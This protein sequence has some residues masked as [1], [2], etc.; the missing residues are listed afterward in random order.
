MKIKEQ[1]FEPASFLKKEVLRI[2]FSDVTKRE[3]PELYTAL[4]K[5][6]RNRRG[7]T[8]SIS[9]NG[10]DFWFKNEAELDTFIN[11]FSIAMRVMDPDVLAGYGEAKWSR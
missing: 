6:L 5:I 2:D 10:P 11:G 3:I 7:K 8:L 1:V 4:V 9:I